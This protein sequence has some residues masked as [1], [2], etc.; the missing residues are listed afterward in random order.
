MSEV[1]TG[2]VQIPMQTIAPR[3]S[4]GERIV[5]TCKSIAQYYDDQYQKMLDDIQEEDDK[6]RRLNEQLASSPQEEA[7]RMGTLKNLILS[8]PDFKNSTL[9][10]P[11]AKKE[12]LATA[13]A[14]QH[15]PLNAQV[16]KYLEQMDAG[17]MS[18]DKVLSQSKMD[19]AQTNMNHLQKV[20]QGAA[21]H[22]GFT[23]GTNILKNNGRVNDVVFIDKQNRRFTAYT[24]LDKNLNSSL[25]LDLE[26][27]GC[28]SNECSQKMSEIIAY[29]NE[30]GIPFTYKR[31]KHNQPEGVIRKMLNTKRKWNK[32]TSKVDDY[33]SQSSNTLNNNQKRR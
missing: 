25:A 7:E 29:L 2:S 20:L 10:M 32:G 23:A 19:L 30:K 31:L 12:V 3:M 8:N 28:D 18:F 5:T 14:S 9:K 21:S 26:G 1:T 13:M 24:K 11:Q 27:F 17:K 16:S 33:L 15:S 4:L 6:I 22:T